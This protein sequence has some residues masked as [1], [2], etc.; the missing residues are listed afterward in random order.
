MLYYDGT[1]ISEGTEVNKTSK[2]KECDILSLLLL[3]R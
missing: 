2:S 1:G 3:F